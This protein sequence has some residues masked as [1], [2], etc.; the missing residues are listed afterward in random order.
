MFLCSFLDSNSIFDYELHF[1]YYDSLLYHLPDY[2]VFLHETSWVFLQ[3]CEKQSRSTGGR[4]LTHLLLVRGS[5]PRVGVRFQPYRQVVLTHL[6]WLIW[7]KKNINL[8]DV[9][10]MA[11][12]KQ[13]KNKSIKSL[14][15]YLKTKSWVPKHIWS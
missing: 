1:E 9:G 10:A 7:R 13:N 6:W 3:L 15:E 12:R 2:S 14:V 8:Q 11:H 4:H 5:W